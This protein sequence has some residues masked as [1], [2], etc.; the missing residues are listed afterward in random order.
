VSKMRTCGSSLLLAV[1]ASGSNE[2]G[3]GMVLSL[4]ARKYVTCAIESL[5]SIR[6]AEPSHLPKS[7]RNPR[8]ARNF[9]RI[10]QRH[11]HA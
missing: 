3:T 10:A 8:L 2:S 1:S 5:T 6:L 4:V 11:H 7:G 9:Q